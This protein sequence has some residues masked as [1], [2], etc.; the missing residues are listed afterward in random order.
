MQRGHFLKEKMRALLSGREGNDGGV[1]VRDKIR[2][3]A[4]RSSVT[5][6]YDTQCDFEGRHAL[7]SESRA[8]LVHPWMLS[9]RKG[10]T[11][12]LKPKGSTDETKYRNG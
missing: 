5:T 11:R 9:Q 3:L 6:H 12:A 7:F 1:N 4:G 10:T 8:R 2:M